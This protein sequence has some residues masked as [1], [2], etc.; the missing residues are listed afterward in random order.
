MRGLSLARD[1]IALADP[2][3]WGF[4]SPLAV[5]FPTRRYLHVAVNGRVV[6]AGHELRAVLRKNVS[7]KPP[8]RVCR[9]GVSL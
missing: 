3:L 1:L 7:A 6:E 9:L 5:S 4:V 8:S 2:L